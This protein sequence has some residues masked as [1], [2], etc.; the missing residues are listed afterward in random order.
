M[1]TVV[2]DGKETEEVRDFNFPQSRLSRAI[3]KSM[4]QFACT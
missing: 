2:V 1:L 3:L 4:M